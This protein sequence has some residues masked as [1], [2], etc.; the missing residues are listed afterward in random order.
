MKHIVF[1]AAILGASSASFAHMNMAN[2]EQKTAVDAS[3]AITWRSDGAVDKNQAWRVPGIMTGGE[4]WPVESGISADEVNIQLFHAFDQNWYGV[5]KAGTHSG[6]S[7]DHSGLELDHA[8]VGWRCCAANPDF[9]IEAGSLMATFSPEISRHAA[10]REFSEVSLVQDAFLGRHFHDEGIRFQWQSNGF[11]TGIEQWRGNAYPATS[12]EGGGNADIFARYQFSNHHWF[13]QTGVWAMK[14]NAE[15]L[16]DHRYAEGH[17]HNTAFV[18][19]IPDVRFSGD[20]DLWG[21][22]SHIRW[23]ITHKIAISMQGELI[24][25]KAQGELTDGTRV[26]QLEG[27]YQGGWL[28]AGLHWQTHSLLVRAEELSLENTLT[29]AGAPQLTIDANLADKGKNP[30]RLSAAWHW[31]WKP[32]IAFR[33]EAIDDDSLLEDHSRI[34]LG[35]VWKDRLWSR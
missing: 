13:L 6:S 1:T 11:S 26:A 10:D 19:Q 20:N 22:H 34:N 15:L 21:I 12:G 2:I 8:Y 14:A 3:A 4:A 31:Q 18:A 32:F 7:E 29:G 33:V 28:Q 25:M 27:D 23:D 17:Q 16:S 5:L 30:A 9:V 24:Q 35:I